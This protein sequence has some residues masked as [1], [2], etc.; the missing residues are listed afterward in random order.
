[1]PLQ[2][3][4]KGDA[5]TPHYIELRVSGGT[6]FNPGQK[7]VLEWQ[8]YQDRYGFTG[9]PCAV[10]RAAALNPPAE[11]TAVTVNQIVSSKALF[12][13]DSELRPAKYN[14]RS[15]E[16]TYPRVAF[17]ASGLGSGGTISLIVPRGAAGKW[18]FAA[19]FIRLDN[20]QF[21]ARPPVE[22]SHGFN[23]Q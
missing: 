14:P 12:I 11:D 23:L 1:V 10:Y 9:V 18:V 17:P 5:S 4:A 8:T 3:H 19:A 22:V 15:I 13:F 7:V 21:P 20:R 16:P 6:D 2:I